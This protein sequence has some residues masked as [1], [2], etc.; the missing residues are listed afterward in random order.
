MAQWIQRL[1]YRLDDQGI[2]I[3]FRTGARHFSRIRSV[4]TGSGVQRVLSPGAKRPRGY[5]DNIPLSTAEVTNGGA[6]PPLL[7]ASSYNV[8]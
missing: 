2:G 5:A 7:R 8:A 1:S 6:I 4:Q 3:R